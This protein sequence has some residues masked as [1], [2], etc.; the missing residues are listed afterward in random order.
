ML[1]LRNF[2]T[3]AFVFLL[4]CAT[5]VLAVSDNSVTVWSWPMNGSP[6]PLAGISIDSTTSAATVEKYTPPDTLDNSESSVRIGLY[7]PATSAW[8]GIVTSSTSFSPANQPKL[9][10][11]MDNTKEIYHVGF[12]ASPRAAQ[13]A[14]TQSGSDPTLAIEIIRTKPGPKPHLNKPIVLSP[15]GKLPE[16]EQEKTLL[17]K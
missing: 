4:L 14:N 11:H 8:R 13:G 5:V 1:R 16:K 9:V 10:L 15:D 17:Q 3:P 7:D 2:V 12:E 6:Q